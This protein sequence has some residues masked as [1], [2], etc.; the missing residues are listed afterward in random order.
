MRLPGEHGAEAPA[1][2]RHVPARAREAVEAPAPA[3]I[4]LGNGEAEQARAGKRPPEVR[5]IVPAAPQ[6]L[7][8]AD[9]AGG[10]GRGIAHR[11]WTG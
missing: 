7:A 1:V 2:P 8:A 5:R 6:V 11:R 3:A 10:G 9:Q 4:L